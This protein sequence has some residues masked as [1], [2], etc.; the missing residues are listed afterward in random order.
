VELHNPDA[1]AVNLAGWHLTD[2]LNNPHKFTFPAFTLAP[3]ARVLIFCSSRPGST[4]AMT[5]S[6]PLGYL[7]TNFALSK[8]GEYLALVA[9]DNPLFP[10]LRS[11]PMALSGASRTK[12]I[13]SSRKLLDRMPALTTRATPDGPAL[14]PAGKF[15][16]HNNV[17]N[18][19]LYPVF[20]FRQ[21]TARSPEPE[22]A[23]AL[24]ALRHRWHRGHT[25]W[26]QDDLFMAWLGLADETRDAVLTRSRSHDRGQR[27]P[28]FWAPHYDWTPDQTHGGVLMT[29]V[30]AMVLQAEGDAIHLLP[31]WPDD[32]NVSFRLHAPGKTVVEGRAEGTRIVDLKVHPPER[33]KDVV[34]PQ[35]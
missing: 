11:D 27:Y 1:A 8:G 20:P 3:G 32:W 16:V 33:A 6:D 15:A 5:V 19:E 30:Q 26:R 7:H 4:G 28:A 23:K 24:N 35:G 34:S 17:E 21:V 9:P 13:P 12:Q 31:A 18:P 29:A 14:A 2:A 10:A 22:R 25:G